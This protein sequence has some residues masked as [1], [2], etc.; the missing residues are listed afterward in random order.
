MNVLKKKVIK[1]IPLW[2]LA[3]ILI[4]TA[5]GAFLWIS[6]LVS[7]D[8]TVTN[9]PVSISGSFESPHYVSIETTSTFDYTVN[10]PGLAIGYIIIEITQPGMTLAQVGSISVLVET[11][12][13]GSLDG[14]VIATDV[15]N[16]GYRFV[17]CE[18]ITM[19]GF[20][21]T[22]PGTAAAG[23]IHVSLTF[24]DLGTYT[25]SMQISGTVS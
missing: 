23:L 13:G 19:L 24:E 1:T 6:N 21:F 7:T 18:S 14:L 8:I 20:D 5:A 25:V 10:N 3:L 17:F 22:A 11:N 12:M 2:M 9:P 4:G 15:I 16:E